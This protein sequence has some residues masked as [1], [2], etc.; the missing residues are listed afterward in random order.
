[1]LTI[2]VPCA[3]LVLALPA[4]SAL[5][6][7]VHTPSALREIV[8]P[9]LMTPLPTVESIVG[10]SMPPAA[11]MLVVASF[12]DDGAVPATDRGYAVGRALNELLF[13][14]HPGLD[15][16]NPN[17]YDLDTRDP[18][19]PIGFARDSRG[20]AYRVARREVAQWCVHGRVE[21]D[22]AARIDV[23]VDRCSANAEARGKWFEVATNGRERSTKS[24]DSSWKAPA[25]RSHAL[26]RLR[27]DERDRCARIASWPMDAMPRRER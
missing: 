11:P 24:A 25:S 7:N 27:A 16:E 4:M 6:A 8:R 23:M 17:Y 26:Q 21:S 9:Y 15:V 19:V 1:M 22:R 2:R 14:A 18:S 3:M 13:G 10:V 5:A 20:D 12:G